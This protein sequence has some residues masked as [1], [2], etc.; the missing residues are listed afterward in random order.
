MKVLV[1]GGAGFIGSHI[2]DELLARGT[3]VIAIDNFDDFYS[4]IEKKSNVTRNLS[5]SGYRFLE[6]DLLDI[7]FLNNTMQGVDAVI[8]EAAQAGVRFSID[9]PLKVNAVNVTGTL[10]VLYAARKSSVRRIVFASSSTVYGKTDHF[11]MHEEDPLRPVSPYGASKVAAEEYCRTFSE[12]YGTDVF[13]L[14]YFS[15]YGPRMRPDL[16]IREFAERILS[17]QKTLNVH[18]GDQVRDW[19]FID[20]IV[21][22]TLLA[23]NAADIPERVFN[24][25]GGRQTTLREILNT[26]LTRLGKSDEV[27][28]SFVAPFKG[29][30]RAT[31]A[32]I[33][34]AT[35][36]LGY[37]PKIS[38]AEGLQQF[39]T[40]LRTIKQQ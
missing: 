30:I 14:R 22:G 2:C 15:V 27:T 20:D 39:V 13:V 12:V 19:T 21:A 7:D 25:G 6:G 5:N 40:W 16:A 36:F 1:T 35:Q 10:N 3:E 23:L 37:N 9:N 18:G 31:Q 26:L 33:R 29:D 8:H 38:L 11:P 24:L 34:R 4:T 17:G 32:D 28:L